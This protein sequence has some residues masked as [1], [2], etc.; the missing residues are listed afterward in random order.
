MAASVSIV[1]EPAR[2][3]GNRRVTCADVTLDNSYPTGGESVTP[4]QLGL[5][6]IE[7]AIINVKSVGGTVNVANAYFDR[8]NNKIKVYDETPAEA[9][10]A[11]DL[12]TLVLQV[13]AYGT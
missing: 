7:F 3:E 12:S 6:T 1:S 13:V 9:A 11:S 4:A 5:E 2:V 8:A 10:N